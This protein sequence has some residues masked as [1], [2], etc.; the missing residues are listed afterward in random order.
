MAQWNSFVTLHTHIHVSAWNFN[1]VWKILRGWVKLFTHV[2]IRKAI[3]YIQK[4]FQYIQNALPYIRKAFQYRLIQE[5]S[6][7]LSGLIA[8]LANTMHPRTFFFYLLPWSLI[9]VQ[10]N[11]EGV[12]Q[13][14]LIESIALMQYGGRGMVLALEIYT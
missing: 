11:E 9:G 1:C 12:I 2:W 3:L 8:I 5:A 10:C 13:S 6:F 14:S 7:Q 4:A